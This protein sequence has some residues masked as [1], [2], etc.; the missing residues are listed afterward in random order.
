MLCVIKSDL[1][2]MVALNE[3]TENDLVSLLSEDDHQAFT[4]I[5]NRFWHK[6]FAV[7]YHRLKSEPDAEEV[8]QDVF[9]SLWRRRREMQLTFT[10]STYLS[11]AVK[12][13]IITKLARIRRRDEH[14]NSLGQLPEPGID[15]TSEW[16]SEKELKER[17]AECVNT[18]PEKCRIV[19]LMSREKGHTHRQIASE[20]NIS[21]KTVEGHISKALFILRRS[22][23]ISLPLLLFI[24]KK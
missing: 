8:V 4:E 11:V 13:Q 1:C 3:L 19:F 14:F 18:L 2:K 17:I 16:L 23:N 12:Y 10:L 22:L 15:S 5:Y 7:A 21:E 9:L 6:L 20:L 24:L